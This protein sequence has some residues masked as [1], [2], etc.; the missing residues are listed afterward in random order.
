MKPKFTS[1]FL[2]VI[3]C[4]VLAYDEEWN[5]SC[6]RKN[7]HVRNAF[8]CVHTSPF[9]TFTISAW[10]SIKLFHAQLH[11]Q[12]LTIY[13]I[14]SPRMTEKACSSQKLLKLYGH[15]LE[16]KETLA[17]KTHTMSTHGLL[18]YQITV[19]T[20]KFGDHCLRSS[21]W[22]DHFSRAWEWAGHVY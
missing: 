12:L 2:H 1:K 21:Q 7:L 6:L 17:T 22:R 10:F 16:I 4:Q 15:L 8:V 13:T 3:L 19:F 18:M 20:G 5:V 9:Y 14:V 11:R